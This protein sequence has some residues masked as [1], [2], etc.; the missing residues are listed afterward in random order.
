[1]HMEKKNKSAG[2]TA[3]VI[4]CT[5][6][7]TFSLTYSAMRLYYYNTYKKYAL[8][9]EAEYY[10]DKYFYYDG[11]DKKKLIDSSIGGFVEGLEDKYSRYQSIELTA[12]R[13]EVQT[14]QQVGIGVTVSPSEDGYMIIEEVR[15][16]TPASKAGLKVKDIII[17][18]DSNDVAQTGYYE[19]VDYIKNGENNSELVMKIKRDGV[20][21][22]IIVK[23]EK[24]DVITAEGKMLDDS[25]GYISISQFNDKTPEQL[26][27]N[28]QKLVS[29]GAKGIVFDVRNNGGG[30]VSSVE[31]CLDPLLPEGDI[32][33]AVFKD[34][35]EEVIVT[36]DSEET[37]IPMAVLI[38]GVS[39]SG[40]ELFAAALRD[41]KEAVLV[42]TT[43]Y[44]KGIM[45]D[46]FELSD[47]S[48]VVLTVAE[49]RTTR[50]ECYHG[51]G[52]VPDHVTEAE[53]EDSDV[54][55]EKAIEV[56]K[57]KI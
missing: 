43:S 56:L 22:D 32:A 16:N 27:A 3:I 18:L 19:S 57:G 46:T 48:T 52:L 36:S 29:E 7:I 2:K 47:K 42:G 39:A 15:D 14:G 49:Y 50:S 44:G 53:G 28:F 1:M 10:V 11:V 33:V 6:M 17:A 35:T 23:R 20:T 40:A 37:D 31:K 26:H 51:V 9:T 5:A 8:L 4:A 12:E 30:L 21:S 34:K 41:F 55:L 25:V 24:I 45:Q 38:N 54:Q 13:T